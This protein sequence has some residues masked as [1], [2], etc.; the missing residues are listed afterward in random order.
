MELYFIRHG[1]ALEQGILARDEDRPLTD[2]G[3]E[4]TLQVA[5]SLAKQSL[6][7][8]GIF[9]SPLVRARQTAEI[10]QAQ[11]LGDRLIPSDALAPG[12]DIQQWI[13]QLLDI[14]N[15]GEGDRIALVGHQPDL[16]RWAQILIWGVA[17]DKIIL[18]KAG[19][20][21][22]KIT[23]IASTDGESELFLLISPRWLT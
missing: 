23:A 5:E 10:L 17:Q 18:K 22:V 9:H 8:E 4:K 13:G 6:K 1:I 20:I 16:G 15:F 3:R 12:G 11:A 19:I 2:K 7:F 14:H 21:G